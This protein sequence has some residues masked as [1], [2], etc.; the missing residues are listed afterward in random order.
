MTPDA[1]AVAAIAAGLT[2]AQRAAMTGP[3]WRW[4]PLRLALE[5]PMC[6]AVERMPEA[7][8][9]WR[10]TPLGLAVRAHIMDQEG[11]DHG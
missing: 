7:P 1:A 11:M 3:R 4:I 2:K 5:W 10:A 6:G 9:F 8:L